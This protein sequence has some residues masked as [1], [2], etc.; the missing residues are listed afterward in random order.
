Q[1]A[2]PITIIVGTPVGGGY[3]TYAR[4]TARHLGKFLP[5]NPAFVVQNM[6]GAGSLIAANFVA[7]TAPKDGTTIGFLPNAVVLEALLGNTSARFD[8]S[9][10]IMLGSLSEFTAIALV[11]HT[12]PF[13]SA[14]DFFTHEV[15]VGA[16]APA[17]NNSTMP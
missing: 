8:A 10:F 12:T 6:P 15:L 1:P 2:K 5:G 9:K 3:D 11:W 13:T 16:T 4:L 17:S 7:N 14:R